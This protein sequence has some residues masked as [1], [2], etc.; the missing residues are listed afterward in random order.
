MHG[1]Q[2]TE[3]G[4]ELEFRQVDDAIGKAEKEQDAYYQSLQKGILD[5][6]VRYAAASSLLGYDLEDYRPWFN[7]LLTRKLAFPKTG[8]VLKIRHKHHL[9]DFHGSNTPLPV[10]LRKQYSLWDRSEAALR[11]SP[12]L[13]LR[14]FLRHIKGRLNE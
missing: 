9:D 10:Q 1:S 6:A 12:L 7:Y 3:S 13:R 11:F 4:Y 2:L 8:E 5:G 14:C